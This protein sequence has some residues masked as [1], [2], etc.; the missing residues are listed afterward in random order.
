MR[1]GVIAAEMEGAST[2]VGRHLTGILHGLEQWEHGGEWHL[3]LQGRP[4]AHPLF[5]APHVRAHFS[6]FGGHRVLWEQVVLPRRL[7][8]DDLDLLYCP[9]YAIPLGLGVPAVVTLH[10]LSFERFPADFSW[11]ERWRR[12]LLARRAARVARRVLVV[13]AHMA[14]EV[15]GLYRVEE[16]RIGVVPNAVE[17][18]LLPSPG[19]TDQALAA[20]G[21]RPPYLL[22]LGTI[23]ERRQPRLVLEA[24][25]ALAAER[26]DLTL[27]VAGANR[28]RRPGRLAVQVAELGL[29]ERVRL[30]GFVDDRALPALYQGAELSLYLSAYEG[31]GMPP[32]ESLAFGTP[33]LVGPGLALDE[34]WPGYPLRVPELTTAAVVELARRCRADPAVIAAVRE[35]APQVLADLTWEASS[36]RLVAELERALE[37]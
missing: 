11:R 23:L 29:A 5:E 13:S 18:E 36:R 10:D 30:L 26:P 12:R 22:W 2:G 35:R 17:R 15:A 33:A 31:F 8:D 25:A 27:V 1:V 32:L 14:R 34:L 9:A 4:F 24:F 6:G 21:V 16:R 3:Y 28:L 20:A 7:R 19:D 37:P